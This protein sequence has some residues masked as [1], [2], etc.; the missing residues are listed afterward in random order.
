MKIN[1]DYNS[2]M[3]GLSRMEKDVQKMKEKLKKD[4]KKIKEVHQRDLQKLREETEE[5]QSGRAAESDWRRGKK[6]LDPPEDWH[7]WRKV[8]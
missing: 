8:S 2:G 3:S 1:I 7:R 5:K 6:K 4:I